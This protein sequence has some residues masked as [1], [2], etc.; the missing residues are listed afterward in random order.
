MGQVSSPH[1]RLPTTSRSNEEEDTLEDA[2]A[3]PPPIDTTPKLAHFNMAVLN[4]FHATVWTGFVVGWL[5]FSEEVPFAELDDA[6]LH[7]YAN[8]V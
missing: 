1:R 5:Y 7:D 6:G 8:G 3:D 2:F 4:L